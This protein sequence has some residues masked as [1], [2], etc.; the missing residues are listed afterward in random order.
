M[1]KT[2]PDAKEHC[3]TYPDG[4]LAGSDNIDDWKDSDSLKLV[5][6]FEEF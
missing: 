2:W 5:L 3:K 1:T 6:V 4:R